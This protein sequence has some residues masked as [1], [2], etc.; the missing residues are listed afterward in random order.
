MSASACSGSV[1]RRVD[2][3]GFEHGVGT[4]RE[5]TPRSSLRPAVLGRDVSTGRLGRVYQDF[6]DGSNAPASR[7]RAARSLG[8]RVEGHGALGDGGKGGQ[9]DPTVGY[10]TSIEQ[11]DGDNALRR[12]GAAAS[13]WSGSASVCPSN[14][15]NVVVVRDGLHEVDG[16]EAKEWRS[17]EESPRPR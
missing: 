1:H 8:A 9:S 5:A 13:A 10:H 6:L 14:V 17:M 2:R 12:F 4:T 11:R 15:S 7:E 3:K 16:T